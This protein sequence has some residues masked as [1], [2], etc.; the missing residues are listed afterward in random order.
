MPPSETDC[1]VE[2]TPFGEH[3]GQ[4]VTLF[5]LSNPGGM[6]VQIINYG[7]IVR[8]VSLPDAAG[9]Y[10]NVVVGYASLA[11]YVAD[12]ACSGA[13]VGRYA[14]RIRQGFSLDHTYYPLT[15]NEQDN[16]LHGGP[17]GLHKQVWQ[18]RPLHEG[19]TC[20]V[21][22]T[23]TSADGDNGFPGNLTIEAEYRLDSQHRLTLTLSASTDQPTVLSL[24]NHSY[25]NL[26][27]HGEVLNHSLQ[28]ASGHI[29]EVDET[30]IPTGRL[31][32][33]AATPFDF[34]QPKALGQDIDSAHPQLQLGHGY[35]HNFVLAEACRAGQQPA[36]TLTDPVS[37][38]SLHIFTDA[39]GLQL[40]SGNFLSDTAASIS[41]QPHCDRGAVALEPQAFPDAPNQPAFPSARI[42][43]T[44][45]YQHTICYQFGF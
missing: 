1:R 43:P 29:T 35:D 26:A 45:P 37:Q 27:G 44:Q 40:Y 7:A 36:A 22:L 30:L 10:T 39:P 21:R 8:A 32:P 18:A 6:Q 12:R 23:T 9:G 13:I 3:A 4:P 34:R 25:F 33:V 28:L 31:L 20:G 41:G 42:S 2:Q 24:T 5:T 17:G 16:V 38:R 14:N 11:D 19:D 15:T